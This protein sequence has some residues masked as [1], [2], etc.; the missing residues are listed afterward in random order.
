MKVFT[1]FLGTKRVI[2][3]ILISIIFIMTAFVE[4]AISYIVKETVDITVENWI[5]IFYSHIPLTLG[6]IVLYGML[7]YISNIFSTVFGARL[8]RDIRIKKTDNLLEGKISEVVRYEK[9][10]FYTFI[11]ENIMALEE[12]VK[13][14]PSAIA[15][16]IVLVF[17]LIVFFSFSWKVTLVCL[18]TIPIPT[19]LIGI[20]N[21]PIQKKT[22]ENILNNGIANETLKAT[23]QGLDIIKTNR[24]VSLFRDKYKS[25]LGKIKNKDV[26]I[27]YT[28]AKTVPFN[29]FLRVFP[30]CLIPIYISYLAFKGECSIGLLPA[31]GLLIG[32]I[33][34]PIDNLL[35]FNV[36]LRS[37]E[38]IILNL[39]KVD[40][41]IPER[42]GGQ[43]PD[44]TVEP[45]I[46]F[47]DVC[48]AYKGK[49]VLKDLSFSV[50][51]N[52]MV[53]IVGESGSGKS[54]IIKLIEG[55][56]DNYEGQINVFGWD[57]KSIDLKKLRKKISVM[58]QKSFLLQDTLRN[59]LLYGVDEY[60]EGSISQAIKIANLDEVIQKL[61]E[62]VNTVLTE[63]GMN[64]S[65]GQRQRV[66]LARTILKNAPLILL[67]EPTSGLDKDSIDCIVSSF[68]T[69]RKDHTIVLVTHDIRMATEADQIILVKEHEIKAVGDHKTLL[70]NEYYRNLY[71]LQQHCS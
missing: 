46:E 28:K 55:L 18:I 3:G 57:I 27:E 11:H 24:I 47:K 33:F 45:I 37:A 9:G 26:E 17:T 64:I 12:T 65:G 50:E 49:N 1:N 5:S 48:F 42:Q 41:I 10:D 44:Y 62:N 8:V 31:F 23:I 21:K 70:S 22:S 29:F 52:T 6:L 71:N 13:L 35:R 58:S 68:K 36:G 53:A 32:N 69:M 19:V 16:P 43:E 15:A 66:A 54:T 14:F 34:N 20:I 67:D 59:N 61:P 63:D 30:Q 4:V 60:S 7:R 56:Y 51:P 38:A 2:V 40:D 25:Q 39:K